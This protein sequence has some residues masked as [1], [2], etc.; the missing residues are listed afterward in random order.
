MKTIST[1]ELQETAIIMTKACVRNTVLE[2]IHTQGKLDDGDMKVFMKEVC[3]K[4]YTALHYL[5]GDCAPEESEAFWTLLK[6]FASDSGYDKPE[7]DH[8][9][10][11]V[12]KRYKERT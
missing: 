6:I 12:M 10:S 9:F 11:E 2:D 7:F 3:N 8:E 4:I 5:V 1:E